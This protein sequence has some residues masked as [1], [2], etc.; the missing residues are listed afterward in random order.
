MTRCVSLRITTACLDEE[1][2]EANKKA[3]GDKPKAEPEKDER[4]DA[5]KMT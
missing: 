4:T 3:M 1:K 2:K 5:E